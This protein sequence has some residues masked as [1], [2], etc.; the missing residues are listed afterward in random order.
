M[1]LFKLGTQWSKRQVLWTTVF[2]G[3]KNIFY[4]KNT[5]ITA[6]INQPQGLHPIAFTVPIEN[7]H[8]QFVFPSFM[9]WN[10]NFSTVWY[11][12]ILLIRSLRIFGHTEKMYTNLWSRNISSAADLTEFISV[13]SVLFVYSILVEVCF[14]IKFSRFS[15]KSLA[16]YSWWI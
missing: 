10:V 3:P 16:I 6:A 13:A 7:I 5:F 4:V 1:H 2:W 11:S 9:I 12:N 14:V 15:I 8:S